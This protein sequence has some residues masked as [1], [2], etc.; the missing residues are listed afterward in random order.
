MALAMQGRHC[1]SKLG[2]GRLKDA[3]GA[4]TSEPSSLPTPVGSSALRW[5]MSLLV[6]PLDLGG[7]ADSA[8]LPAPADPRRQLVKTEGDADR[9][10]AIRES[11]ARLLSSSRAALVHEQPRVSTSLKPHHMQA[12]GQVVGALQLL[13]LRVHAAA[14]Q[15]SCQ[16]LTV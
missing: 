9:R 14:V 13:T 10:E 4:G 2:N 8:P 16:T 11:W 5:R 7:G 15:N 1:R 6:A 3:Y 12:P